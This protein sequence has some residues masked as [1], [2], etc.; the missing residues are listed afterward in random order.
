M[1]STNLSKYID[2]YFND[3]G[4]STTSLGNFVLVTGIV[5]VLH[6]SLLFSYLKIKS[7]VVYYNHQM[8]SSM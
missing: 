2:V 3:L 6:Q 4:Q 5:S 1:G 8:I 7:F